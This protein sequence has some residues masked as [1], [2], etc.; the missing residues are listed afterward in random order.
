[1]IIYLFIF[2]WRGYGKE[3][4]LLLSTKNKKNTIHYHDFFYDENNLERLFSMLITNYIN[5]VDH[6]LK[7]T[8]KHP[9]F[10]NKEYH[11]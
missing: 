6:N 4:P 11:L 7:T 3:L 2:S 5:E 8:P 1:M 10:K 9:S